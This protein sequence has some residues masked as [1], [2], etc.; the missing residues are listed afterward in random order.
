MARHFAP[1]SEAE[2]SARIRS[3][4]CDTEGYSPRLF[5]KMLSDD[6]KVQFDFENFEDGSDAH[7]FGPA[8]LMGL[9]TLKNGMTCH[10]FCAGGDWEHPVFWLVYY[11]GKQLRGYI[12]GD[13]NPWNTTTHRAF[14]N[15][16]EADLKNAKK[17]W[18]DL[19]K[20][21]LAGDIEPGDFE[22]DSRLIEADIVA[23]ILP[24]PVKPVK[25]K[26]GKKPKKTDLGGRIE[27]LTYYGTGDEGYELFVEACRFAHMLHGL[28]TDEQAKTVVAWAE[29]MASGSLDWAERE[30]N[31]D[32]KAQGQWGYN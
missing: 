21:K 4:V 22:F 2:L 32:D 1:I 29:D 18:P 20:D 7:P 19:F 12:P 30:G 8:R 16:D 23:R 14:G 27:A 3:T 17:R 28:G 6:L 25:V 24:A 5:R 26:P 10:G 11:D 13:G 15:D 31:L 9:R